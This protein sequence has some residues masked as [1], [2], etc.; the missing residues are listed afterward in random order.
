M[1][2]PKRIKSVGST[3]FIAADLMR[4]LLSPPPEFLLEL[5]KKTAVYNGKAMKME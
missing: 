3:V 5:L 2:R 1:K 4:R